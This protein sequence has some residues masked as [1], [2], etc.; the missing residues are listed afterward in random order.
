MGE[1][2]PY[3]SKTFKKKYFFAGEKTFLKESFSPPHPLF[4]RTFKQKGFYFF[5]IVCAP[6]D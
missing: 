3:L 5:G 2:N 1:E 4:Q 6:I